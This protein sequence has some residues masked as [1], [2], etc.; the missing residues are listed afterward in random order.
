MDGRIRERLRDQKDTLS[1]L[2]ESEGWRLF[3][4]FMKRRK[5]YF[6]IQLNGA[7]KSK[8]WDQA[9]VS[10]ALM[11]QSESL[12][13]EFRKEPERLERMIDESK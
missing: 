4:D 12:I 3:E 2:L 10:H 11:E 1:Q 13:S 8:D 6:Q 9:K 5:N 7:V